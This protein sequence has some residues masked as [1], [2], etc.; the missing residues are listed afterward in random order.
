MLLRSTAF[1]GAIV[2][3]L[4]LGSVA[5]YSGALSA[6]AAPADSAPRNAPL[7]CFVDRAGARQADTASS[8]GSIV[9]VSVD[10][11]STTRLQLDAAGHLKA[12][13]TN[14]GCAPE[15][16]DDFIIENDGTYSL[17]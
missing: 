16:T 6:Q 12:V 5:L 14:T 3:G 13:G 15:S 17:A 11:A 2:L 8:S 4:V 1:A 10:V 7:P 9:H